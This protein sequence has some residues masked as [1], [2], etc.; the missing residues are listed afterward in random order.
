MLTARQT[1]AGET[2]TDV[3]ARILEGQ[4]AW[5]R[6]PA[7]TSVS[8]RLLLEAALTKDPKQRLPH[9]GGSRVF[10]NRSAVSLDLPRPAAAN[11]SGTRRVW[12]AS[13]A[14]A[15][16]LVAAM[17]PALL[18]FL[19]SPADVMEMRFEISAPVLGSRGLSIAVSPDG[20]FIAYIA[21][22]EGKLAIW[23]RPIG[24]W[25]ARVLA[26]TE[27]AEQVFWSPD[28]RHLGFTADG[29]LKRIDI[30]GG[31]PTVL[32]QSGPIGGGAWN[33]AGDII[34]TGASSVAAGISRIAA[35]GETSSKSRP[36]THHASA[37]AAR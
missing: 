3:I 9:I 7:E 25:T 13:A 14:L 29:K 15:I 5:D 2:A 19:R 30:S 1:F 16:V 27:N 28:G 36:R 33:R 35:G 17:V 31:A 6:L 26:G 12:L 32:A 37:R 21:A 20:R 23:I 4:P 10:L 11:R 24:S 22:S 18:Y 34:F 8:I